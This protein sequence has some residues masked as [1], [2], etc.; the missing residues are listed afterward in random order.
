MG[1]ALRQNVQHPTRTMKAL[2]L[3]L[4][5]PINLRPMLTHTPF[6]VK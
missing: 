4:A 2:R 6:H 1:V 3:L 5:V